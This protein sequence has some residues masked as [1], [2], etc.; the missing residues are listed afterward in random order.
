M[1]GRQACTSWSAGASTEARPSPG[2]ECPPKPRK[3]GSRIDARCKGLSDRLHA[4]RGFAEAQDGKTSRFGYCRPHMGPG[5]TMWG[6][7]EGQGGDSP[8]LG[9]SIRTNSQNA[10]IE[11]DA[12]AA[13]QKA[14]SRPVRRRTGS[15]GITKKGTR[16]VKDTCALFG[17][18]RTRCALLTVTLP[19]SAY[20]VAAEKDAW[21]KFQTRYRDCLKA[22]MLSVGLPPLFIGV[23]EVGDKRL[24][25][26]KKPMPHLH[27]VVYGWGMKGA[28]GQWLLSPKAMDEVVR[29]ACQYAGLPTD[30]LQ[31]ASRVEKIRFSVKSYLAKYLTKGVDVD[32]SQIEGEWLN[33][34]PKQW[35]LRTKEIKEWLEGH[36]FRLPGDFVAFVLQQRKRLE[37]MQIG[38]GG[39]CK[40]AV[41][42][43]MTLGEVPIYR[44][45]FH[46]WTPEHLAWALEWYAVWLHSPPAFEEAADGWLAKHGEC[47]ETARHHL[48]TLVDD[49]A[50]LSS[51]WRQLT[52]A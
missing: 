36:L 19:D 25:R 52:P 3:R 6:V 7:P 2:S 33:C 38:T 45:F 14:G 4:V 27:L 23:V 10:E 5:L 30:Q 13:D 8:S 17:E 49:S 28:D 39:N 35:W 22:Y 11:V 48:P 26:T 34:I 16:T 29:R 1:R 46:F 43:S 21:W 15:G 47:R 51:Y 44:D 18:V 31:A 41:R 37:G 40:I 20:A 50:G 9:L 32:S 24:A 42:K 12:S